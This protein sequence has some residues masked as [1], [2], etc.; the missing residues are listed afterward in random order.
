MDATSSS[1]AAAA[2]AA[3][4]NRPI[5]VE[6]RSALNGE[7]LSELQQEAPCGV[8]DLQCRLAAKFCDGA[9]PTLLFEGSPLASTDFLREDVSLA[10]VRRA[11][12]EEEALLLQTARKAVSHVKADHLQLVKD[13]RMP[14]EP[15][16]DVLAATMSLL[17]LREHNWV[18][19]KKFL[20]QRAIVSRLIALEPQQVSFDSQLAVEE[21]VHRHHNSFNHEVISRCSIALVPFATLIRAF[22]AC[23]KA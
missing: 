22:L 16:H 2:A 17:D 5:R 15:L 23:W 4:D 20:S 10:V 8:G 7:L 18:S 14:P 3:P 6:L 19:M 11:L 21:I 1:S 9:R 12:P 13:L